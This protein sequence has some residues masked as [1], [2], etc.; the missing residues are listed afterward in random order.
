MIAHVRGHLVV[1][2][3]QFV[4]VDVN[5]LGYKVFIPLSTFTRLPHDNGDV[6]LHTYTHV[7]EDTLSLY[8]FLSADE[9]DF[10]TTL[11]SISGVGPKMGLNLLSGSSLSDLMKIVE[12]EDAKRLSMIPG[13]G[14][15]TAARI[16]LELKE[17]LPALSTPEGEIHID[18]SAAVDA[19]SALMNLGY[20]RTQAYEA[21]KRVREGNSE[22][23]I[24]AIIRES[25]KM[26]SRG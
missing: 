4:V 21:I 9:R 22:M 12:S 7:R 3:P 26:L 2:T 23:S 18:H 20:Q 11:L 14:K 17:K 15:K 13:V 19:L 5:G 10:F 6:M 16:I 25:L 8:G 24:E 1:K